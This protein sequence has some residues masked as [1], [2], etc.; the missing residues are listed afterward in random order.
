MGGFIQNIP[1]VS[2]GD[3]GYTPAG[4]TNS[5]STSESVWDSVIADIGGLANLGASIYQKVNSVN[6][7]V[8]PK[9]NLPQS[10][11]TTT[12]TLVSGGLTSVLLIVAVV[13][14]GIFLLKK[15]V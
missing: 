4:F 6:Q 10:S 11:P 7:P 15:V 12:N 8:V 2:V 9:T 5:T 14:G 13:F 1:G 3:T